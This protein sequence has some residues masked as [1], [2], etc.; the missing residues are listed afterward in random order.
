[1]AH[2]RTHRLVVSQNGLKALI[3]L[4][5]NCLTVAG[6][7]ISSTVQMQHLSV[8][9]MV[10]KTTRWPLTLPSRAP[11]SSSSASLSTPSQI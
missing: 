5:R 7:S 8:A 11:S 6:I 2:T 10:P 1:M 4:L 3:G 9:L